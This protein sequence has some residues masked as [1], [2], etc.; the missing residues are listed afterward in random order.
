MLTEGPKP[1]GRGR[2]LSIRK[3]GRKEARGTL[4]DDLAVEQGAV[5]AL[6]LQ[7]HALP[8]PLQV[9]VPP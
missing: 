5:G 7:N 6:V 9:A 3:E 4:A 1:L 2:R 8:V